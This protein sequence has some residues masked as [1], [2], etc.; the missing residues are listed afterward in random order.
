MWWYRYYL[1]LS[2]K[3]K[4]WRGLQPA[5]RMGNLRRAPNP[6][7]WM[8]WGHPPPPPPTQPSLIYSHSSFSPKSLY[9]LFVS[10]IYSPSH[11]V[12]SLQSPCY[13]DVTMLWI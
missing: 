5:F 8:N 13:A 11:S 3:E 10:P 7:Q 6:K 12:S 2:G 9:P 1:V 4:T